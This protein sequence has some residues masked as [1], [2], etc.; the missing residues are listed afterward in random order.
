MKLLHSADTLGISRSPENA[1]RIALRTSDLF[2][3]VLKRTIDTPTIDGRPVF[4]SL[5]HTLQ[6]GTVEQS[7]SPAKA[8]ENLDAYHSSDEVVG[9]RHI[10]LDTPIPSRRDLP[11]S[12]SRLRVDF[13]APTG[14]AQKSYGFDFTAYRPPIEATD[15]FDP[16]TYEAPNRLH[17]QRDGVRHLLLIR[18]HARGA[19]DDF[20]IRTAVQTEADIELNTKVFAPLGDLVKLDALEASRILPVLTAQEKQVLDL[21]AQALADH[22]LR[23]DLAV[24]SALAGQDTAHPMGVY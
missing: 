18:N 19:Q 17:F 14:R 24:M 6:D 22:Q 5:H 2:A 20:E 1:R 12:A 15:D 16:N 9:V 11:T 8:T 4:V 10:R 3:Q 13:F 7:N 21:G 23:Q